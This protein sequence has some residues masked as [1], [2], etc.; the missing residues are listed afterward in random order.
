MIVLLEIV[1]VILL[2]LLDSSQFLRLQRRVCNVH[3]YIE[4]LFLYK[5][6]LIRN[7]IRM[8]II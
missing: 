6:I 1:S 5:C 7:V 8:C 3:L 2:M 4:S